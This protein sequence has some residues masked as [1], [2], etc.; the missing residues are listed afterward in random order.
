MA[1]K[2]TDKL[3]VKDK[4]IRLIFMILYAIVVY[5]VAAL[6]VAVIA[7][8]Q[9]IYT[10]FVGKPLHTLVP[11]SRS[12]SEYIK[13]VLAYITY[14]TETKPFPFKPWPGQEA[15]KPAPKPA[16][17]KPVAKKPAA[18]KALPKKEPEAK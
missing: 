14:V 18:K 3:A 12:L 11:F 15:P 13:E 1:E 16:A 17:K 4:W 9:F 10:L 5:W 2:L 6:V 7:L 8:F